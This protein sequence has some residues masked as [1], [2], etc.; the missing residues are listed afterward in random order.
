MNK[1]K[2]EHINVNFS[3]LDKVDFEKN[4]K[5]LFDILADNMEA[6]SPTGNTRE[7]DYKCWYG[8]VSYGLKREERQII[9]IKDENN[10][11]GFFQYYI[12]SAT[13]VVEEIQIMSEFQGRNIFRDLCSFLL[14]HNDSVEFIEAY[15]NKAN[16]KSIGILERLGFS[17]I[18][19]NKNGNSYH[20]KGNYSDLM[21]W[22]KQRTDIFNTEDIK[23]IGE[24]YENNNRHGESEADLLDVHKGRADFSLTERGDRQAES[25]ASYISDNYMISKIYSGTL[26]QAKDTAFHLSE[27]TEITVIL[28][29]LCTDFCEHTKGI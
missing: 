22:Y 23:N 25:M 2:C 16:Y 7:E 12:N 9:L 1:K 29:E 26:T 27:K 10:I 3:F 24:S 20:F 21:K 11:V 17:K 14:S 28:D 6:I 19:M 15:A 18:G 5:I 13:F 4:S 8:A